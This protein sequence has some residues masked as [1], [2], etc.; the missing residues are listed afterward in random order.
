M[1]EVVLTAQHREGHMAIAKEHQDWHIHHWR[2]V[3]FTDESRFTLN[4]RQSGDTVES[5]L[6]PVSSDSMT[7]LAVG[8]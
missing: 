1:G 5:N 3:L 2:P 6:L 4:T 8:Q 7:G